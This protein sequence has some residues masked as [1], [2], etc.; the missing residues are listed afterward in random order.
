MIYQVDPFIVTTTVPN[1]YENM[2]P[3]STFFPDID[4]IGIATPYHRIPGGLLGREWFRHENDPRIESVIISPNQTRIEQPK[5]LCGLV[6]SKF[7]YIEEGEGPTWHQFATKAYQGLL[8]CNSVAEPKQYETLDAIAK[9]LS[10]LGMASNS[11]WHIDMT[12][13]EFMADVKRWGYRSQTDPIA[14]ITSHKAKLEDIKD[15][16]IARIAKLQA[17]LTSYAALGWNSG[18]SEV[19]MKRYQEVEK[20]IEGVTAYLAKVNATLTT[21]GA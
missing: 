8:L 15:M 9:D 3:I 20:Q 6:V 11:T 7:L 19:K 5:W 16:L 4:E 2:V 17:N 10:M 12:S 1:E 13:F 14:E 18:A 21:Y